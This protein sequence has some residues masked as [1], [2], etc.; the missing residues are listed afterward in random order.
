MNW[1]MPP[2][3]PYLWTAQRTHEAI[4]KMYKGKSIISMSVTRPES[5]LKRAGVVI[6]E[7]AS[8]VLIRTTCGE[9][10]GILLAGRAAQGKSSGNT[11]GHGRLANPPSGTAKRKKY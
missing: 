6:G 2:R 10:Q 1:P 4:S 3:Q 8:E 9:N 11:F 5:F 7:F